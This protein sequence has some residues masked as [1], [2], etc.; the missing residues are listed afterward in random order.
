MKTIVKTLMIIGV[1][2]SLVSCKSA[3][4]ASQTMEKQENRNAV[5]QEIISSPDQLNEF[6][7]LAQKDERATKIIMNNHMKMMESGKMKEMMKTNPD[8]KEKMKA[9][10]QKMMEDN[11]EMKEKMMQKMKENPEMMEA[12]MEAM[13]KNPEMKKKMMEKMK[14]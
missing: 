14:N 8:M 4:N 12:M 2:G 6:I 11:P 7:E 5:Y 10:M 1:I 13:M 3:F 9:H